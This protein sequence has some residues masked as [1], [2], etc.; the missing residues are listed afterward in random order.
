MIRG[1]CRDNLRLRKV[2]AVHPAQSTT[3]VLLRHV[4]HSQRNAAAVCLGL[5]L[6]Q[7]TSCCG[8]D[9]IH[10]HVQPDRSKIRPHFGVTP[11]LRQNRTGDGGARLAGGSSPSSECDVHATRNLTLAA[12]G[13]P[14]SDGPPLPLLV[15][16]ATLSGEPSC[17]HAGL[18]SP[19]SATRI[20]ILAVGCDP[21]ASC[22]LCM[23]DRIMP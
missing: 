12:R 3:D 11:C 6:L 15:A 9:G 7:A 21:A 16:L 13:E 20:A 8:A 10:V 17:L 5:M 1:F 22:M 18:R 4:A 19:Q 14:D 2:I 23:E